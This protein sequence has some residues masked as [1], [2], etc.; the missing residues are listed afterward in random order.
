MLPIMV[1]WRPRGE[2]CVGADVQ[3]DRQRYCVLH[4]H[5]IKQ[6]GK[7]TKIKVSHLG[8]KQVGISGGARVSRHGAP[9]GRDP[10]RA[11][12]PWDCQAWVCLI[13]A[14]FEDT[15]TGEDW[16]FNGFSHVRGFVVEGFPS[17]LMLQWVQVPKVEW[18]RGSATPHWPTRMNTQ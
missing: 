18:V 3:R 4:T 9:R 5:K 16:L 14:H 15:F 17:F 6:K 11:T 13:K 7:T 12:G 10:Y 2:T 8:S 1:L